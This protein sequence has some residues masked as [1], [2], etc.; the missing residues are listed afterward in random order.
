MVCPTYGTLN[1]A[2]NMLKTLILCMWRRHTLPGAHDCGCAKIH[3]GGARG[4]LRGGGGDRGGATGG[5]RGG[6]RGGH[7]SRGGSGG[8][9]VTCNT[10]GMADSGDP[11]CVAR[12]FEPTSLLR[13]ATSRYGV[14]PTGGDDGARASV[15]LTLEVAILLMARP[16]IA[17]A[18]KTA[19]L[20]APTTST[21][22]HHG[23]ECALPLPAASSS[24]L[25][26]VDS[27]DLLGEAMSLWPSPPT[28]RRG[29]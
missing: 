13:L 14:K 3:A 9:Q 28:K 8:G 16:M 25:R 26:G 7:V 29:L 2:T 22:H 17:A 1:T 6:L 18:V 20:N 4:G 10:S 12:G 23:P 24:P 27:S 5:L 11:D 15:G 21:Q 19:R